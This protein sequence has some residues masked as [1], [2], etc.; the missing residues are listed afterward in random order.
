MANRQLILDGQ[1]IAALKQAAAQT[2][3]PAEMKRLQAIRL[4]GTGHPVAEIAEIVDTS[5][6]SIYRWSMEYQR[7][8]L[9]ALES[10]YEGNQNAAKLTRV[11][12]ID[13]GEKLGQYKPDQVLSP[14]VRVSQGQFWTISDLKIAVKQWYGVTYQS[15]TSYRNLFHECDFSL[16][17]TTGQYR[18][19][20]S[21]VEVLAFE[22]QLEKK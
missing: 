10:K 17:R 3:D 1:A 13:L 18:S 4:F 19:R 2:T 21:Q 8:G 9:R 15:D 22:D 12:K 5:M 7:D 11:Q 14:E 6:P 16:Q 20:A